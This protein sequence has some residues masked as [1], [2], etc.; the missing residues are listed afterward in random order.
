MKNTFKYLVG[1][2]LAIFAGKLVLSYGNVW[3][4]LLDGNGFTIALYAFL[5]LVGYVFASK[6]SKKIE[7]TYKTAVLCAIGVGFL[8][9]LLDLL[10]PLVYA[11]LPPVAGQPAINLAAV[12]SNI[13]GL[14]YNVVMGTLF[15]TV[16]IAIGEFLHMF[17]RRR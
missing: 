11:V 1:A 9:A 2:A 16:F 7:L 17:M 8:A 5:A 12:Y 4:H 14:L 15:G 10:I 6:V 13:Y 3:F